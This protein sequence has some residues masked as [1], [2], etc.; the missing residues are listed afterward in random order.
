MKRSAMIA[1]LKRAR[2]RLK[3]LRRAHGRVKTVASEWS[4][5]ETCAKKTAL[6]NYYDYAAGA[7]LAALHMRVKYQDYTIQ[8]YR[9]PHCPGWHVGRSSRVVLRGQAR[10]GFW[11]ALQAKISA[12]EGSGSQKRDLASCAILCGLWLRQLLDGGL[13]NNGTQ[14]Q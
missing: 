9:C 10:E 6:G 8:H 3:Q 14:M 4:S 13:L 2:R 5:A 12:A 1:K 11:T 7:E